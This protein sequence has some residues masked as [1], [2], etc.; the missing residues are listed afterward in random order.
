MPPGERP[1]ERAHYPRSHAW[2]P[3]GP[4]EL[5]LSRDLRPLP[6]SFPEGDK[7]LWAS[8]RDSDSEAC[9]MAAL[10]AWAS[11]VTTAGCLLLGAPPDLG[12]CCVPLARLLF[13]PGHAVGLG[14]FSRDLFRLEVGPC[15]LGVWVGPACPQRE[16]G[17]RHQVA[18]GLP[19]GKA[20]EQIAWG[21]EGVQTHVGHSLLEC[22]AASAGKSFTQAFIYLFIHSSSS[23]PGLLARGCLSWPGT[24]QD[25]GKGRRHPWAFGMESVRLRS[26]LQT[27]MVLRGGLEGEE[28][29]Q[30]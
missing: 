3:Q 29:V 23:Q 9:V 6:L 10:R 5:A 2:C 18:T 7:V 17:R 30:V 14:D 1:Q 24:L 27:W 15:L 8:E 4:G 16:C 19:S 26:G 22:Q 13:A 11:A 21:R 12:S 28:E 25:A 20:G